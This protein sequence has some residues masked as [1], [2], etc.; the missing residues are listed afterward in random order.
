[1]ERRRV[2]MT[3]R[4]DALLR[5]WPSMFRLKRKRK[6]SLSGGDIRRD[7]S[8]GWGG[9]TSCA[10]QFSDSA[11]SPLQRAPVW[12]PL[13]CSTACRSLAVIPSEAEGLLPSSRSSRR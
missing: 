7:V 10:K 3:N 8:S 13:C 6:V 11:P 12:V 9:V 1:M 4:P 2:E 5:S